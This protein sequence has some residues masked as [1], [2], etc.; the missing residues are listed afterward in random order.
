MEN[1]E[2][3]SCNIMNSTSNPLQIH[4]IERKP[5]TIIQEKLIQQIQ[6]KIDIGKVLSSCYVLL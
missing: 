5:L 4:I 6:T 3:L 2:K 1:N